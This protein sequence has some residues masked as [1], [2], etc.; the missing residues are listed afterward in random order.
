M[1]F[2]RPLFV[3]EPNT[4]IFNDV[5]SEIP[6]VDIPEAAPLTKRQKHRAGKLT[7][8]VWAALSANLNADTSGLTV[9]DTQEIPTIPAQ[10]VAQNQAV[11][12]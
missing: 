1:K 4:P 8:R 9:E 10:R 12:A 5:L 7:N 3:A 11:T 2:N 6:V